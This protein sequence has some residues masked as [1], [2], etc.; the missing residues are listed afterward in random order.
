MRAGGE[1][2][3]RSDTSITVGSLQWASLAAV[4]SV[5]ILLYCIGI[6]LGFFAIARAHHSAQLSTHQRERASLL[7]T[8][9]LPEFWFFETVDLLRKLLLTSVV[10]L[11]SPGTAPQ[12]WLATDCH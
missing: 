4:A 3:L 1:S 12:L 10:V 6:P 11:V 8:S 2:F 5:G 9:Y 7:L